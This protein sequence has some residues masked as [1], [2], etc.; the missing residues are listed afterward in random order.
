MAVKE[1]CA[2]C[3]AEPPEFCSQGCGQQLIEDRDDHGDFLYNCA[4]E[5]MGEKHE[6]PT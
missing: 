6:G 2:S 5:A 4:V 1:K 3:E